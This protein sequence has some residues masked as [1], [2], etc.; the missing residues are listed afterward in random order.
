[1]CEKAG[2]LTRVMKALRS[3]ECLKVAFVGREVDQR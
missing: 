1:V 2:H 3:E